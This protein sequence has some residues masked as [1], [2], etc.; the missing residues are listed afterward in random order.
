M[1][2]GDLLERA[3]KSHAGLIAKWAADELQADR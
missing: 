1:M 3:A 2:I